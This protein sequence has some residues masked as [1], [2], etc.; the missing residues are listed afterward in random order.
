MGNKITHQKFLIKKVSSRKDYF[1]FFIGQYQQHEQLDDDQIKSFLACSDE[2]FFR[3]A[4]CRVPDIQADTFAE[5]IQ[6]IADFTTIPVMK[7]AQILKRVSG[8]EVI[9]QAEEKSYEE[10]FLLAARQKAE[11]EED[12]NNEPEHEES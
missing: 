2:N 12:T 9:Q 1:A 5:K 11:N 6:K 3:L 4:L 8:L 7:L 10:S